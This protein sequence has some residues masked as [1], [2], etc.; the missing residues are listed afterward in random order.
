MARLDVFGVFWGL[1]LGNIFEFLFGVGGRIPAD[2]YGT[3]DLGRGVWEGFG[4]RVGLEGL[5]G[6]RF[7]FEVV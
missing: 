1:G 5:D 7:V 4:M 3:P 6:L 2:F